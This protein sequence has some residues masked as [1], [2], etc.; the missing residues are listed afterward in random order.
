MHYSVSHDVEPPLLSIGS[1]K[2]AFPLEH[3]LLLLFCY[4]YL[5]HLSMCVFVIIMLQIGPVLPLAG[6]VSFLFIA[7]LLNIEICKYETP[8]SVSTHLCLVVFL[9]PVLL[10]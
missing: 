7:C 2:A 8:V 10:C 9:P 6:G 3:I 1:N 4:S 5:I